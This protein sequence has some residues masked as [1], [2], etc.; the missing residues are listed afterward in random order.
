MSSFAKENPFPFFSKTP[1]L[2]PLF[3]LLFFSF[4]LSP[5]KVGLLEMQPGAKLQAHLGV[6]MLQPHACA[7][8]FSFPTRAGAHYAAL[9][10]CTAQGRASAPGR[11]TERACNT[12]ACS[13]P[14]FLSK[15][16]WRTWTSCKRKMRAKTC[17][18]SLSK[19]LSKFGFPPWATKKL[20]NAWNHYSFFNNKTT[21]RRKY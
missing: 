10:G 15:F 20:Y 13:C 16:S 3:F 8:R 17:P 6:V 4:F 18:S 7:Q 11:N 14:S 2:E 9:Q 19:F 5:A 21:R 1:F 12:A